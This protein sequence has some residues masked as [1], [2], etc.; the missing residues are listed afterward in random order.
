MVRG[1]DPLVIIDH[2]F[3][4]FPEVKEGGA[5]IFTFALS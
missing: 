4:L 3:Y 5:E 1:L 2:H